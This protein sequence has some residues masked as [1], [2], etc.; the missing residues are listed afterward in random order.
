[1]VRAGMGKKE[2]GGEDT[3]RELERVGRDIG[4]QEI[5][6]AVRESS[7]ARELKEILLERERPKYLE[8]VK[9]RKKKE[10]ERIARFRLGCESR[11][12]RYWMGKDGQKCR[13]CGEERETLKHVI[14]EC[15][16]TGKRNERVEQVLGPQV[17]K[18]VAKLHEIIGKRE[19][20]MREG[21][22]GE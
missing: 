5:E 2:G 18:N 11:G 1:M 6:T 12:A 17:R 10:I 14:E 13:G 4:M 20:A 3:W 22:A 9:D 7:Y 21:R 19:R 16:V 8:G 15:R